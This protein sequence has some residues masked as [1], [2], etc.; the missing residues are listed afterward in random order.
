[1]KC[2]IIFA[3]G[4]SVGIKAQMVWTIY[5]ASRKERK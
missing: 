4:V 2:W 1:M 3:L 5:C